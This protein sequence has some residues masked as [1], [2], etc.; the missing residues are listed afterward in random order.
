MHPKPLIKLKKGSRLGGARR[1]IERRFLITQQLI[2][3]RVSGI[4]E[5]EI[6]LTTLRNALRRAEE[7]DPRI[8]IEK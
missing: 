2:D 3:Q 1:N 8:A 4:R 6:Q 7:E 5:R